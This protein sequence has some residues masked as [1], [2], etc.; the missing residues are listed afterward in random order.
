MRRRVTL[1]AAL[2][3]LAAWLSATPDRYRLIVDNLIGYHGENLVVLQSV[4]DNNNSHYDHT[5]ER[6]LVEK[7]I[8]RGETTVLLH[9]KLDPKQPAAAVIELLYAGAC[10]SAFP[11]IY[12]QSPGYELTGKTSIRG[13]QGDFD[14]GPF[15]PKE[16]R[17]VELTRVVDCFCRYDRHE[18]VLMVDLVNESWT[19]CYRKLIVVPEEVWSP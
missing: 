2:L 6:Y 17:D 18:V 12:M 13:T 14:L 7:R 15:I 11:E 4:Y 10:E 3:C 8:A 19:E 9:R 5:V 16:L 1:L